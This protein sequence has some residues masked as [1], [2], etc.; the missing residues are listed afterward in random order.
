[1]ENPNSINCFNTVTTSKIYHPDTRYVPKDQIVFEL[2]ASGAE[3]FI[4]LEGS[5]EFYVEGNADQEP[6]KAIMEKLKKEDALPPDSNPDNQRSKS[7]YKG[8]PQTKPFL[9]SKVVKYPTAGL[10]VLFDGVPMNKLP[11][12]N[13]TGSYFGELAL[14]GSRIGQ[15]RRATILTKENCHFAILHREHYDMITGD[16]TRKIINL[17][18]KVL[19]A[20]YYF[21]HCSEKFL[22]SL[23]RDFVPMRFKMGQL[24]LNWEQPVTNIY[25]IQEGQ[26]KL[27]MRKDLIGQ[28]DTQKMMMRLQQQQQEDRIPPQMCVKAMKKTIEYIEIALRET[29]QSFFEENFV[30]NTPSSYKAICSSE[31]CC[32]FALPFQTLEI[33]LRSFDMFKDSMF[34]KIK[35][36]HNI[37]K[38]WV[39]KAQ[40]QYKMRGM[41]PR[42]AFFEEEMSAAIEGS[43]EKV[44]PSEKPTQVQ[45]L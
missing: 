13:S 2:K 9:R 34:A 38:S 24:I 44:D 18:K 25:F 30:L 11:V 10:Q 12:V 17:R 19:R 4:I 36:H 8:V 16:T 42:E 1:M 15:Q 14:T 20:S 3:F 41:L 28:T 27:L 43:K 7:S 31:Y 29:N 40:S 5:V 26:V 22:D 23:Q 32:V 39:S 35:E 37:L 33:T 21:S 6:T 45:E